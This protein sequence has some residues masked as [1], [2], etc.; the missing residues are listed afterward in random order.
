MNEGNGVCMYVCI[1]MK[2]S[3]PN[4]VRSIFHENEVMNVSALGTNKSNK[5]VQWL[6]ELRYLKP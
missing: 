2:S 6:S 5:K 3:F 4:G 1:Y